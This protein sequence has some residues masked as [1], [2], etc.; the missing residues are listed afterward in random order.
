[1]KQILLK[2]IL[3]LFDSHERMRRLRPKNQVNPWLNETIQRAICERDI[4]YAV[5]RARKTKKDRIR[6]K[7][8]RKEV[9]GFVRTRK[10]SYRSGLLNPGFHAKELWQN[11]RTV[12]VAKSSLDI[13][14]WPSDLFTRWTEPLLFLWYPDW[15]SWL[16]SSHTSALVR[17]FQ[18]PY[19]P[20]N[21]YSGT[22]N[23]MQLHPKTF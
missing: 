1:M 20:Q 12:G 8:M 19:L 3:K 2:F 17:R 22:I 21:V 5:W 7:I 14:H 15:T 11:L 13:G 6:F 18:F 23:P 10:R 16:W 4:C 9:T